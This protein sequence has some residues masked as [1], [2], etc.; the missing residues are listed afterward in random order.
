MS[1]KRIAVDFDNTLTREDGGTYFTDEPTL[2]NEEMI[3]WVTQQYREGHTIIIWTARPW[4]V[5]QETAGLLTAWGVPWHG[6]RMEKGSA[7][8]YVDDKMYAPDDVSPAPKQVELSNN[9]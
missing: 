9:D 7:D 2:P 8:V 1:E 4:D 6:L 3:E 5:A